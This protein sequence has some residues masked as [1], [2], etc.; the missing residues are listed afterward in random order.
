MKPGVVAGGCGADGQ[1]H[2]DSLAAVVVAATRDGPDVARRRAE[3]TGEHLGVSL[4]AATSE[5]DGGG[6]ENDALVGGP[7]GLQADDVAVLVLQHVARRSA[8]EG[9]DTVRV[10]PG[11]ERLDHG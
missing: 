2:L 6:V 9:V 7:D 10:R 5:D 1:R 11:A 8:I 4:E 3:V